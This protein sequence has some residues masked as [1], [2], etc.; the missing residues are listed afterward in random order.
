MKMISDH[1]FF[2]PEIII[3]L[4]FHIFLMCNIAQDIYMNVVDISNC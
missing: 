2:L 3:W 1:V 4:M